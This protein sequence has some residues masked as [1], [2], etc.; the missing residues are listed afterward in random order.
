MRLGLDAVLQLAQVRE[1]IRERRQ[2]APAVQPKPLPR[3][4][5]LAPDAL[6]EKRGHSGRS[7]SGRD[8][9]NAPA[10]ASWRSYNPAAEPEPEPEP[11]AEEAE[12]EIEGV[13]GVSSRAPSRTPSPASSDE[14]LEEPEEHYPA[15]EAPPP[16]S[17]EAAAYNY[18]SRASARQMRPSSQVYHPAGAEGPARS[19][20]P[21]THTAPPARSYPEEDVA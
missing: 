9:R 18:H 20:A 1:R 8:E 17:R 7:R 3:A 2:A 14:A 15:A 12:A 13:S 10:L 11:G 16:K 5:Q 21:H 19:L 6:F 4:Q